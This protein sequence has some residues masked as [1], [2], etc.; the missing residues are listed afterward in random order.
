MGNGAQE[1]VTHGVLSLEHLSVSQIRERTAQMVIWDLFVVLSF[2][3]FEQDLCGD[4]APC[5][6]RLCVVAA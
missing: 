4:A 5:A 2:G 3:T 1:Y 6:F